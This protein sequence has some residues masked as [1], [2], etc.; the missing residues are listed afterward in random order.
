MWEWR[1]ATLNL[2]TLPEPAELS[3]VSE[4]ETNVQGTSHK[5]MTHAPLFN[6][7]IYRYD[8]FTNE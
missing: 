2:I 7:A 6:S 5:V 4:E 1:K 8:G 3:F